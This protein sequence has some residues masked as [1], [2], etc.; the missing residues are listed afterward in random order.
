MRILSIDASAKEVLAELIDNAEKNI[1]TVDDLMEIKNGKAP[2]PGD[3]KGFACYLDFGF[4]VVFSIEQHPQGRVRHLSVSVH[5]TGLPNPA[6]VEEIM[7]H[8][9]FENP[10]ENCKVDIEKLPENRQAIEVIEL[11]E[12]R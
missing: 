8:L 9:K 6:A 5:G 7:K 1:F 2:A 11:I 10:M 3:R 4:R 12:F